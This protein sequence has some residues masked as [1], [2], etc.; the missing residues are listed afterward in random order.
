MDLEVATLQFCKTPHLE[1]LARR[2]GVSL[3]APGTNYHRQ[4]ARR[5]AE[6]I[7]FDK[8]RAAAEDRRMAEVLRVAEKIAESLG[9]IGERPK[10]Q[11][12]RIVGLMGAQWA[13]DAC[14]AAAC[15]V[16]GME[17]D[18]LGLLR[19]PDGTKR[20]FG[21]VFFAWC[22]RE[23]TAAVKAGRITRRQFFRCFT[24]RPKKPKVAKAPVARK[25]KAPRPD[26]QAARGRVQNKRSKAPVPVEVYVTRRRA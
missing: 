4:L 19:L 15:L 22:R 17:P 6:G 26:P 13:G 5:V 16:A 2:L 9:E 12:R 20:T 18:T 10:A 21:G 1:R 24:D 14:E 25:P 8:R 3:P 11:I 7:D 23:A